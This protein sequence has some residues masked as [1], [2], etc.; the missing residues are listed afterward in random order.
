MVSVDPG[1]GREKTSYYGA[2]VLA[3]AVSDSTP[4]RA[5]ACVVCV[6]EV[7]E[8]WG[9]PLQPG[10]SGRLVCVGMAHGPFCGVWWE[11]SSCHP[12]VLSG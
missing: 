9:S 11:Q 8:A 4:V 12:D 3:F 2:E 5:C 10:E 1:R 7:G 6:C